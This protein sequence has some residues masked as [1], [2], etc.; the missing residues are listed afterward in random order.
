MLIDP[1][2]GGGIVPLTAVMERWVNRA[3]M[4]EID[5]DIAAFWQAA[6]K[7]GP[8]MARMVR[9]F[10]P[11]RESVTAL[12]RAG[13]NGVVESGFRTLVINRTRNSGIMAPG[14]SLIRN[15]ENGRGIASRWY[16]ETLA[17]RLEA[18]TEC[19]GSIVF[20]MEDGIEVL[21]RML[22]DRAAAVFIDPPYT[23]GGKSAGTR[24][25]RHSEVDHERIFGIISESCSNFLMTYDCSPEIVSLVQRHGFHAAVVRMKNAHHS[26]MRELVI[27]REP[28]F[29]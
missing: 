3:V 25:Y 2:T 21:E 26:E 17:E 20:H 1:F 18:I 4:V 8:A 12:E 28:M 9:E 7:H 14:A 23:A 22:P 27:T 19:S 6:L 16:P 10:R 24:L 11:T 29:A 5:R 15:G 13:D